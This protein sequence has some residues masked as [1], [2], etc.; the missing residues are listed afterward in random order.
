MH[1]SRLRRAQEVRLALA[2]Q[3]NHIFI[4]GYVD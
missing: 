2:F 4:S 3:D 1:L